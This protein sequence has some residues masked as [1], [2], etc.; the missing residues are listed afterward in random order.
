MR[1]ERIKRNQEKLASLGLDQSFGGRFRKQQPKKT[2]KA[3]SRKKAAA[4]KPGEERRSKRLSNAPQQLYQLS[5]DFEDEV[6]VEQD[7]NYSE[8]DD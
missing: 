3:V 7:P 1:L 6:V 8:A 2:K 4:P 5:N